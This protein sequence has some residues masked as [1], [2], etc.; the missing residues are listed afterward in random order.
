MS[1]MSRFAARVLFLP[2]WMVALGILVKGY[3]DTGDGF[4]AGVVASLGVL[5]QYT[6][7]GPQA[8]RDVWIVRHVRRLAASGLVT[9][10]MVVFGPVL[11]GDP[12]MTHWPPAEEH[13][14][15]VGSLELTTAFLFDI[16]VF[17]LVLGFC[18]G[19]I[20]LLAQQGPARRQP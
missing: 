17:L 1:E 3:F 15:H 6:A 8:M 16:G 19:V 4:G 2:V 11:A 10:L 20:D 7:F 13:A 12:L 9:A 14:R 18:I 5:M